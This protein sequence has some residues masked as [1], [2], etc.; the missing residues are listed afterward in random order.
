MLTDTKN[1]EDRTIPLSEKAFLILQS[2][3]RQFDGRVFP[4][5]RNQVKHSSKQW[6]DRELKHRRNPNRFYGSKITALG[7]CAHYVGPC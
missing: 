5:T 6:S 1:G 2:Q 7:Q 3:P 4:M